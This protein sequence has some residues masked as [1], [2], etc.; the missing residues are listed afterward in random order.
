[1]DRT[2]MDQSTVPDGSLH[3]IP[4]DAREVAKDELMSYGAV[5]RGEGARNGRGISASRYHLP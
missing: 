3:G 5:P 2:E 1:M 4:L